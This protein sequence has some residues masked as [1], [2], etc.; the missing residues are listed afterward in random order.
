[1]RKILTPCS[2]RARKGF[3]V[4]WIYLITFLELVNKPAYNLP[5][6]VFFHRIVCK[7]IVDVGVRGHRDHKK[8]TIPLK[9]R[10]TSHKIKTT[11]R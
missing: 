3:K 10:V 1:M 11:S 6:L 5:V 4:L 2:K 8:I 9:I 7:Y